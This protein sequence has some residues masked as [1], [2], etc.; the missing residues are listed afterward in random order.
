MVKSLFNALLAVV[1]SAILFTGPR[2]QIALFSSA[3]AIPIGAMQEEE[4]HRQ[5]HGKVARSEHRNKERDPLIDSVFA[6]CEFLSL[7]NIYR[8]DKP[9]DP[10]AFRQ[11]ALLAALSGQLR[12]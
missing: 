1:L 11:L 6:T 12:C 9:A 5:G 2:V 10:T 8:C 4:E 7:S 3:T